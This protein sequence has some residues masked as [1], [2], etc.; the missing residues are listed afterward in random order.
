M[1]V[2][3]AAKNQNKQGKGAKQNPVLT[4][5]DFGSTKASLCERL[6]PELSTLLFRSGALLGDFISLGI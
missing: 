2:T 4:L 6:G 3:I 5:L 1:S